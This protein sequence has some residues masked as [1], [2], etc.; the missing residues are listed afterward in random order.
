[1]LEEVIEHNLMI[2]LTQKNS[3]TDLIPNE[4]EGM[5]EVE[6]IPTRDSWIE[7]TAEDLWALGDEVEQS[8]PGN[9]EFIWKSA[10]ELIREY[11]SHI[12]K[13]H[14]LTDELYQASTAF[15]WL[16]QWYNDKGKDL[17][18]DCNK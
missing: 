9:L 7:C 14:R 13:Y 2:L 12:D 1:L 18:F 8:L 6:H 10:E 17:E 4:L 16:L 5:D 11:S 3:H 15:S